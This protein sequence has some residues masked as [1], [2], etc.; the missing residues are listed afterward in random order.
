MQHNPLGSDFFQNGRL[1]YRVLMIALLFFAHVGLYVFWG[2]WLTDY[3][4]LLFVY[5]I[6][7]SLTIVGYGFYIR[8][9]RRSGQLAPRQL[10]IVV[11]VAVFGFNATLLGLTYGLSRVAEPLVEAENDLITTLLIFA[12]LGIVGGLLYVFFRV[13]DVFVPSDVET[14]KT[15]HEAEDPRSGM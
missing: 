3:G 7:A 1:A 6:L 13:V 15:P 4:D 9:N 8:M 12:A 2:G 11:W 14:E 5:I 10:D